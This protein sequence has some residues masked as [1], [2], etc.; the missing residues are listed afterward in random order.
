MCCIH[1]TDF[2]VQVIT[3]GSII[4]L[5]VDHVLIT[6]DHILVAGIQHIPSCTCEVKVEVEVREGS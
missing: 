1:H 3:S 2:D 5:L 6:Q 4:V